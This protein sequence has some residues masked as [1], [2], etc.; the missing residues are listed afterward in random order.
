MRP[1]QGLTRA[2]IQSL[3]DSKWAESRLLVEQAREKEE[4]AT[5]LRATEPMRF[6]ALLSESTRLTNACSDLVAECTNLKFELHVRDT[7]EL[8]AKLGAGVD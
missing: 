1:Y 3:I 4:E 6:V 7:P 5:P 2:E 8:V